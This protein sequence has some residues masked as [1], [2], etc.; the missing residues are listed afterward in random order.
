MNLRDSLKLI[1]LIDKK[2]L[3]FI[4]FLQFI[5]A[6]IEISFSGFAGYTLS[7]VISKKGDDL[8]GLSLNIKE[9]LLILGFLILIRFGIGLLI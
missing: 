9:V 1:K 8:F 6:S 2:E 7:R 4:G 5:Y 3:I